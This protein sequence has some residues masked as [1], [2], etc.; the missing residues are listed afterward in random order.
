MVDNNTAASH[1]F[2][3][4]D[5]SSIPFSLD[6]I[7][8]LMDEKVCLPLEALLAS[9]LPSCIYFSLCWKVGTIPS[10]YTGIWPLVED[11]FGLVGLMLR[12]H[13][14]R[15]DISLSDARFLW[16]RI[17]DVQR[18]ASA[19]EP[20]GRQVLRVPAA[21]PA[22]DRA[23]DRLWGR[24]RRRR[25]RRRQPP[26]RRLRQQ[27]S[28]KPRHARQLAWQQRRSPDRSLWRRM[29]I[30]VTTSFDR[31]AGSSMWAKADY[32]AFSVERKGC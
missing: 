23:A 1:S 8:N 28:L 25:L 31:Q 13:L 21:R 19:K 14:C 32:A 9:P 18:G 24:P 22:E 29:M 11:N 20:G 7:Q 27:P 16:V 12:L 5:D 6:D 30:S 17:G 2:L 3:L 10:A 15:L 26:R 4:D